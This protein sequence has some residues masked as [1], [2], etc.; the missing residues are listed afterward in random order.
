MLNKSNTL[1]SAV[2]GG[3]G[4]GGGGPAAGGDLTYNCSAA[5]FSLEMSLQGHFENLEDKCNKQIAE[6]LKKGLR[7][8]IEKLNISV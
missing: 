8:I 2:G 4:G 3:G 1:L 5:D 6:G 7:L